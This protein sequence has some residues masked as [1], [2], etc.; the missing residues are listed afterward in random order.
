M[1]FKKAMASIAF[2]GAVIG[3]MLV[4]APALAFAEDPPGP[5]GGRL[6]FTVNIGGTET[7]VCS[8]ARCPNTGLLVGNLVVC[9]CDMF[10]GTFCGDDE[11]AVFTSEGIRR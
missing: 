3:A 7:V 9:M 5:C 10:P 1:T 4:S 8:P 11:V 6:S 2:T